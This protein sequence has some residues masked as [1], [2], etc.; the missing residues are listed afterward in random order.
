MGR[1]AIVARGN[2]DKC[3]D[4]HVPKQ[5]IGSKIRITVCP[6]DEAGKYLL[7]E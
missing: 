1:K 3:P 5:A 4:G 7:G 6:V 2:C